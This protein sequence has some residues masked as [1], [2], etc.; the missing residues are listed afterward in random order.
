MR[1]GATQLTSGLARAWNYIRAVMGDQAYERYLEVA[2]REGRTPLS[3][4]EFYVDSVQ[5]RYS[6]VNRCC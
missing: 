5:R 6:T 4:E 2:K 1:T 3:A